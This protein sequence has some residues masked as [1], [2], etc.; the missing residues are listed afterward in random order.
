METRD[1]PARQRSSVLVHLPQLLADLGVPLEAVLEGSGVGAADLVPDGFLSFPA[2]LAILE[3]AAQLTGYEDLGLRL[4]LCQGVATLGP[5]AQVMVR[6]RTLGEGL[7]DFVRLQISNSTGGAVYIYR[8]TSD[9][10]LGYGIYNAGDRV[11]AQAHDM[12]L[13]AGCKIV[14]ELTREQVK[15]LELWSVRPN[16][17]DPAPFQR[18]ANCPIRFGQEQTC[19][20]LPPESA[21]FPLPGADRASHDA[22][23]AAL[24]AKITSLP[25]SVRERVRHSLRALLLT[26]ACTMP[27]V[28][29]R[30]GY[31]PRTLRRALAREG[32][33]FEAI[34][35]EVRYAVARELLALTPLPISELALALN[36]TSQ[37]G[38]THAFRR[39]SGTSP[40]GWRQ[41]QYAA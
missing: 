32:T 31:H 26:G 5:A 6:A 7:S 21:D 2:V 29:A 37:S 28:A 33:S 27:L 41:M 12:A 19:L 30:L 35:D 13:A 10:A 40:T 24:A 3:R 16:P 15:P 8:T 17:V 14:A 34:K 4:G 1:P 20:F 38:F 25:W 36:F 23:Q 22:A 39:W 9:F 11:S 18:L